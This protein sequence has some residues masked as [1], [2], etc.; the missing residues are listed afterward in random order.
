M[1]TTNPETP[2]T[3]DLLLQDA[4]DA[5]WALSKAVLAVEPCLTTPYP[6]AP[7]HTP[8]S[9]FIHPAARRAYD[10]KVRIQRHL[11]SPPARSTVDRAAAVWAEL[12]RLFDEAFPDGEDSDYHYGSERLV[13]LVRDRIEQLE[14]A[15]DEDQTRDTGEVS[16]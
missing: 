1:T 4:A 9:R 8:W 2:T 5:L 15:M 12:K 7:E 13:D 3:P 10:L 16:R 14:S 11:K 6:D